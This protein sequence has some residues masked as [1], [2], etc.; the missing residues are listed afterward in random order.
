MEYRNFSVIAHI[1]HGKSTLADRLLERTGTVAGRDMK[2]QV[3]DSLDLERER[4]ITI[5]MQ[6]VRMRHVHKNGTEYTLTM[7]DTPGHIDFAYEVSRSLRAVEGAVVLVDVSQGVQAQTLSVVS[8]AKDAGLVLVPALSKIDISGAN[9]EAV[10][11]ELAE[12]TGV[13]EV[14]AVS[15][16]TG[17][18][19]D[20]LLRAIIQR[21]P[22]PTKIPDAGPKG[23]IFDFSYTPHTGIQAFVR[24]FSGSFSAGDTVSL[25][26]AKKTFVIKEVGVFSPEQTPISKLP[27]GTVGYL[28]TGIKEPGVA[29]VGDTVVALRGDILPLEGYKTPNPVLW[30]SLFPE[31]ADHFPALSKALSELRLSDAAFS[32]EEERSGALGKGF[33]C[34]FLGMLHLEIIT[35]RIIRE[36]GVDIITTTPVTKTV[37]QTK[38]GE[39]I[40]ISNPTQF[41]DHGDIVGVKELWVQTLIT[42]P[43]GYF[44]S[45][46][47]VLREYEN[48]MGETQTLTLDRMRLAVAMPLREMMRNFFDRIKSVTSGYASLSYTESGHR[49][50]DLTRLDI[51]IA[52]EVVPAFSRVVSRT[53]AYQEGKTIVER[54]YTHLPRQLFVLK[55]QAQ[56][57]GRIVASRVLSALSKDVTGH[58]YGGDQTRKMKLLEKQ[59]KGKKRMKGT[60][61]VRV[62]HTVFLKV[63]KDRDKS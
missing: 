16:R 1:D 37:V 28:T 52:G 35:E 61:R 55:I 41:P 22:P 48:E 44:N 32:Y 23:L 59:K 60:G 19:V 11:R 45:I 4:G 13:S 51:L 39:E 46:I 27:A 2:E 20:E 34:G 10:S 54:L 18:G 30:A 7:I 62:P 38:K 47:R 40:I 12:L 31:H 33:R 3:L 6:P 15:G 53:R 5:K 9:K 17:A 25:L 29:V 56:A 26:G 49:V 42:F 63:L 57:D 43:S 8:A 58:L 21:V 36:F 50:G 14:L 24:V